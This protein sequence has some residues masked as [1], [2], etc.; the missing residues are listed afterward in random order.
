MCL[1][2]VSRG[3]VGEQHP[4]PWPSCCHQFFSLLHGA[5]QGQPALPSFGARLVETHAAS[6]TFPPVC[7]SQAVPL[8][9]L[10]RPS[11]T[12]PASGMSCPSAV[13]GLFWLTRPAP[14]SM[15]HGAMHLG[16]PYAFCVYAFFS[17]RRIHS[18]LPYVIREIA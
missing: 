18:A 13:P 8:P 5:L 16:G 17:P 7:V 12:R 3:R 6:A 2:D 10:I 4:F 14:N 15:K 11:N 9:A 1:L